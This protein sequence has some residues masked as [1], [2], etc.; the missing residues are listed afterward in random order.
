MGKATPKPKAKA[1]ARTKATTRAKPRAKPARRAAAGPRKA[2]VKVAV[3]R[4]LV[5]AIDHNKEVPEQVTALSYYLAELVAESQHGDAA[6][7][8]LAATRKGTPVARA[9][10][11]A[12]IDRAAGAT[13]SPSADAVVQHCATMHRGRRGMRTAFVQIYRLA[14]DAAALAGAVDNFMR[15]ELDDPDLLAAGIDA[16]RYLGDDAKAAEREAAHALAVR[17]APLIADLGGTA[18]ARKRAAVG[19]AVLPPDE[20][21]HVYRRIVVA[22]RKY[23]KEHALAAVLALADDPTTSTMALGAAVHELR[24]HGGDDLVAAWKQ[25]VT[26]GDTALIARLIELFDDVA[27]WTNDDDPLEPYIHALYPAGSRPEVFALAQRALA[28]DRPIVRQ[29][30]CE[31]WLRETEG[32]RGFTDAQID[33]LIRAA[34]A[35][36]I[37]GD[38]T[39]DRRAANTALFYCAHP[40]AFSAIAEA[41]RTAPTDRNDKLRW[42]LYFALSHIDHPDVVPLLIERLFV[43]D[44]ELWAL[45]EAFEAKHGH[46]TQRHVLAAL[47]ARRDDRGAAQAAGIYADV[48]IDKKPTPRFLIEL[49]R[50]VAAWP[51]RRDAMDGRRLRYILEQAAA[52]ALAGRAL[53]DARAFLAAAD[54]LPGPAYSDYWEVDRDDKTPKPLAD[55]DIKKLHAKLTSGALD[56]EAEARRAA[57]ARAR[58]AG[59]PIELDDDGLAALAGTKVEHRLVT[60]AATHEVWF[61]DDGNNLVVYDGYE[62]V[63]APCTAE[64]SRLREG[65][66]F[67][68]VKDFMAGRDKLAERVLCMGA[69]KAGAVREAL[70][71]ADRVLLYDGTGTDYWGDTHTDVAGFAFPDEAGAQRLFALLRDN[72]PADTVRVDPW[73]L[74]G[75]GAVRRCYYNPVIGGGYNEDGDAKIAIV[76]AE[77]QA[78]IDDGAPELAPGPY[79]DHAAAI[80]A[81]EDWEGALYAELSGQMTK[82]RLDKDATR[83]EDTLLTAYFADRYRSDDQDA[84]W[85]LRALAEMWQA[86]VAAG[87]ADQ[88]PD[89]TIAIGPPATDAEIVAYQALVPEP[90]PDPLVAVW[91]QV[92]GAGFSTVSRAVRFLSPAELVAQRDDLRRRHRAWI[93]SHMKGRARADRLAQIATLDVIAIADGDPL[94]VFDTTQAQRDGRCF[95]TAAS[96]WWESA[97]GWQIATDIN[98]QLVSELERRIGDV[99]RLKLGQHPGPGT[100]RTRLEHGDRFWE[101][102]VDG[103]QLMTRFGAK[104]GA[105]KASVKAL[106]T[107]K[108]AA[109]AYAKAIAAQKAKG[110]R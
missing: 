33:A 50:I 17:L 9:Y 20:Q 47:D 58:A 12:L 32:Q 48:L 40:G 46:D 1:R 18:P 67:L 21:R 59:T 72:P 7:A 84:P 103:A 44:A 13:A 15:S 63:P 69:K 45:M 87:L 93:E 31:E 97:L 37:E 77:V 100:R 57:A 3:V 106:A 24:Y 29:T 36:A 39:G 92:G 83:S 55:P 64:F 11:Q 66:N 105:G 82:I 109:D 74:A 52:A 71:F 42:N 80:A 28:S 54:A 51:A 68:A 53:A 79:A 16:A 102:I 73:Y 62:V 60:N 108:A 38:D 89:V 107:E 75:K 56:R 85:H 8:V 23:D 27:V 88:A 14:T 19:L 6:A 95:A 78:V 99:F 34:A 110:Y 65:I 43:E 2:K 10:L 86:V 30:A 35:I 26:D 98:V 76:G 25:R 94:I 101:A 4:K 22:P 61:L 41:L 70:R 81:V 96:D 5:G 90:L 104:T 91:R 49:G